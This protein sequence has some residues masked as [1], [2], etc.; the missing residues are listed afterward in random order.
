MELSSIKPAVQV[1]VKALA[2]A[3]DV[4]TTTTSS[5]QHL[6]ALKMS[7]SDPRSL[8]PSNVYITLLLITCII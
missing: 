5:Q 1:Q 2:V 6:L 7:G 3:G 4:A 8:D